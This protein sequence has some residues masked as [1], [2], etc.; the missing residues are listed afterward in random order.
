MAVFRGIP[1]HNTFSYFA[2]GKYGLSLYLRAVSASVLVDVCVGLVVTVE[3]ALVNTAVVAVGA[4]EWLCAI[5]V[6]QVILQVVFVFSHENAFRTEEQFFWLDVTPPVLPEL[7]LG[8]GDELALLTLEGL[9]LA[10]AVHPG[11]AH[12]GLLQV[13]GAQVVLVPQVLAIIQFVLQMKTSTLAFMI[14]STNSYS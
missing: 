6:S 14:V 9:D 5:V 7:N 11:C 2:G 8:D 10:L 13:L 3:H 4:L 1:E 12:L